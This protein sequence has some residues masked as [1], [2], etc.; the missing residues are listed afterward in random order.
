MFS[1]PDVYLSIFFPLLFLVFPKQNPLFKLSPEIGRKQRPGSF[2]NLCLL[3]KH[4]SATSINRSPQWLS[5]GAFQHCLEH[6][7]PPG[8]VGEQPVVP[9]EGTG[10]GSNFLQ[11]TID[12]NAP[13]GWFLGSGPG[14]GPPIPALVPSLEL[15]PVAAW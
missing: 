15:C 7:H 11:I 3:P 1:P 6:R 5:R 9:C 14:H 13:F 4:L 10:I 2:I 12:A 8:A